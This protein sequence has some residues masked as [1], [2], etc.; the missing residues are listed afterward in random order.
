[1]TATAL[2]YAAQVTLWNGNQEVLRTVVQV[3][4]PREATAR[5]RYM[6]R[7]TKGA[8]HG[9]FR[10]DGYWN[11]NTQEGWVAGGLNPA[12]PRLH[13]QVAGLLDVCNC[14]GCE[15]RREDIRFSLD[16]AGAGYEPDLGI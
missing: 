5:V 15:A 9:H 3:E 16:D 7:H 14:A 8:T 11:Q 10:L 2:R 6:I 12:R 13:R 4:D 1:M